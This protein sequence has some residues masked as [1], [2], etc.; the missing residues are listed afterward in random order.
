MDVLKAIVF[1]LETTI[2]EGPH[3]PAAKDPANDFHTL[4]YGQEIGDIQVEHRDS[5]FKR[6]PSDRFLMT[7]HSS[8]VLVGH[9]LSFDLPYI[10]H[11]KHVQAWLVNGGKIW[12]T[13]LAEYLMSGQRHTFASLGELQ[14]I[15]LGRKLKAD[16]I[17]KLYK[18][19]IGADKI[20]AARDRCPRLFKLYEQY[21]YDDGATTLE[22]YHHQKAKAIELGMDRIIPMFQ[23]YL[24]S[25]IN[26]MT[27]GIVVDQV[28]CEKTLQKFK[29]EE[30]K[31]LQELQQLIQPYWNDERLPE[32][33]I[34]SNDHKSALIFGG[35]IPVK[36]KRHVGQYKNGN[37]K[38]KMVEESVDIKGFG[39]TTD[40]TEESKKAGVYKTGS[41]IMRNVE[42]VEDSTVQRY[43][44]IQK[45]LMN[46]KKMASTYLGAF[47]SLGISTKER[48][49][50]LFPHFNITKTATSRLSSSNPNLQNCLSEDTECLTETGWKLIKDLRPADKVLQVDPYSEASNFVSP[51]RIIKT[52]DQEYMY[53]ISTKW[54]EFN[55]TEGHR[56]LSYTRDDN[57]VVET[58]KEWDDNYY[59][60]Q[61]ID[62]QVLRASI[63]ANNDTISIDRA[64][65]LRKAV[66]CQAEG[67]LI[68]RKSGRIYYDISVRGTRKKEQL[69]NLFGD[70]VR[71]YS[72]RDRVQVEFDEV[73][74]WLDD[75]KEKNFKICSFLGLGKPALL[76]FL[77][78]IMEWDGDYTRG[79]TY[80]QKSC[81][82]KSV[83]VVQ[84]VCALVGKSTTLY[85]HPNKDLLVVNI[86][87]KAKRCQSRTQI[88][89]IPYNKPAYCVEVDTGFFLIRRKGTVLVTG[90]CPSKGPMAEAIQGC[91]VAPE[92]WSCVQI[93]FSQ[94]EIYVTAWLS[95]DEAMTKDLL[96]GV[97][98]HCLRLSWATALAEGK[99]Y[100]EI[101][102]LAKIKE[103][104]AWVLKRSKAK[105]ISY[106]KAYGA[107]PKSL[108]ESTGL[109]IDDVKE[110]LEKEDSIYYRVKAFNDHVATT[111][112]NNTDYSQWNH[113]PEMLKKGGV[114]GKRFHGQHEL[115]PIFT[116]NGIYYEREVPRKI[117]Y[118]QSVT[119][120]RYAF[121]Q[122]GKLDRNGRLQE[123]FSPT[124]M[125][126]YQIQGTAADIQAVTT[127]A[128][129][130]YVLKESDKVEFINEIH[131]SKLFYVRNDHLKPVITK[132]TRIME[133][134]PQLFKCYL[135]IDMPFSVPVDVEIGQNFGELTTIKVE[136]L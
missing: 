36:V 17:S 7:L 9:N 10:W 110:L 104:P 56:I 127:A 130:K 33:K 12:D 47:I 19:G 116:G 41:D 32:F 90:N 136:D 59:D 129:L 29:L 21:S 67:S 52:C 66:V 16:R 8:D 101:V 72:D 75:T 65:S 62:R 108:S 27:T 22:I 78:Y 6:E 95:G 120:K 131:D 34:N 94:L 60:G 49:Y 107:G 80:A 112:E 23:D 20:L 84:A 98:F 18:K 103:D 76:L 15:Y 39:V 51:K 92:G 3:G 43:C 5:G 135:G 100:D 53:N 132:L 99:S 115:L 1:D 71:H 58:P 82:K 125:K 121:E 109:D 119:G 54:G 57:V 91:F 123:T 117:G 73:S 38:F 13:Q 77:A 96:S 128:L 26:C 79:C 126:N 48:G 50:R 97:D 37:D 61:I 118:Y 87:K 2:S 113:I 28:K 134:A 105:T 44:Q 86:H 30:V 25:L 111:V 106:Q 69:T 85:R 122:F 40:I 93:D 64:I 89:K 88:K 4:I 81:R 74:E 45:E 102:E 24:L 46:L 63:I 68:K 35:S 114:N 83:E 42:K 70:R 31:M 124:Q 55:Y 11:H 14:R 133:A